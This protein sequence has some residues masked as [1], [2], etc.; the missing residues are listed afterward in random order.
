MQLH[1]ELP[2][3]LDLE[4]YRKQAKALVRAYGAGEAERRRARRGDAR[5]AGARALPPDRR[6]VGDRAGARLP[7]V[8]RVRPLGRDAGARAAGRPHRSAAGAS[9]YEER[10]RSLARAAAS[11]EDE[12]MRR[13]R[14]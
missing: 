4:W 6:A 11:G 8:G 12:A 2:A 14:A 1:H 7:H 9:G 3:R 10:A 13:V 5:R